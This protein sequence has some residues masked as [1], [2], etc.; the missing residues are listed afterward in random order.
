MLRGQLLLCQCPAA[1][2]VAAEPQSLCRCP[3][4]VEVAAALSLS[5]CLC[6]CRLV[7]AAAAA[8][9]VE[10][11][12]EAVRPRR[13]WTAGRPHLGRQ[14]ARSFRRH[15]AAQAHSLLAWHRRRTHLA[16]LHLLRHRHLA[17][18]MDRGLPSRG[19]AQQWVYHAQPTVRCPAIARSL[20]CP[21]ES[22]C[23]I[24]YRAFRW[25]CCMGTGLACVA[26]C[27]RWR[28]HVCYAKPSC[29]SAAA[30]L[31]VLVSLLH[32]H[33]AP[34]TCTIDCSHPNV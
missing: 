2:A 8:A 13:L 5:R 4:A 26:G 7:V 30:F 34:T 23:L 11:A 16:R 29:A 18:V 14:A 22:A 12:A 6:L 32:M 27:C 20:R 9:A 3:V 33:A 25:G 19:Q 28:P 21:R 17:L 1:A 24:S 15:P 10:A 31:H